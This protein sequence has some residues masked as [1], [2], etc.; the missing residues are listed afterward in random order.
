LDGGAEPAQQLG[1]R[2]HVHQLRHVAKDARAAAEDGAAEDGKRRVL[3]ARYAD[4]ALQAA[5]TLDDDL[6]HLDEITTRR[7]QLLPWARRR[8]ALRTGR[9]GPTASC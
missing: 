8:G 1:G 2:A 5:P 6:V 4:L 7:E 3:G 9:N